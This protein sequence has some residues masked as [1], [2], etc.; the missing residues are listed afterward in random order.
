[1]SLFAAPTIQFIA[2]TLLGYDGVLFALMFAVGIVRHLVRR[3]MRWVEPDPNA[4]T[5]PT[6][7][8]WV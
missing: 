3:A 8:P 6:E 4:T 5:Y 7:V 1:M 2:L